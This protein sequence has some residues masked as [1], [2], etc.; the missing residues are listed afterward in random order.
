[1]ACP[2]A[3]DLRDWVELPTIVDGI[4]SPD[5]QLALDSSL[6]AEAIACRN[7]EWLSPYGATLVCAAGVLRH[8]ACGPHLLEIVMLLDLS[9]ERRSQ[10]ERIAADAAARPRERH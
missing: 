5:I 4:V 3:F 2:A 6:R 1:M 8:T 10:V 7:P 9:P